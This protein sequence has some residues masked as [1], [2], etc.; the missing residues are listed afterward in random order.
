MLSNALLSFSL[1]SL[2]AV[3]TSLV[4]MLGIESNGGEAGRESLKTKSFLTMT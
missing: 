2:V 3:G 1:F 4:L